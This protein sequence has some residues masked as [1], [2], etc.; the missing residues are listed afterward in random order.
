[1]PVIWRSP[2]NLKLKLVIYPDDHAP[3]HCHFEGPD[4][5][6]WIDLRTLT[7]ERGGAPTKAL[8]EA[9]EYIRTNHDHVLEEWS[10]YCERD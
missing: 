8:R 10:I 3:P 9:L 1:M 5:E 4:F 2:T 6:A 7:V